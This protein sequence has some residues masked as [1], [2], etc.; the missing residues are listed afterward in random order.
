ME[1]RT[2]STAAAT[3]MRWCVVPERFQKMIGRI[4]ELGEERIYR[5]V[6]IAR[7]HLLTRSAQGFRRR[8]PR[9]SGK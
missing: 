4:I 9:R 3:R 6:F 8:E 2:G 7:G 5:Y 1:E